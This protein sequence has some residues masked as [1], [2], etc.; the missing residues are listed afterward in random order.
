MSNEKLISETATHDWEIQKIRELQSAIDNYQSLFQS[1]NEGFAFHEVIY[2][3]QGEPVD[4]IFR[5][6]NPKFEEFTGLAKSDILDKRV[7]ECIP[8]IEKAKPNLIE[9]YGLIA[10]D[11]G[12]TS[13]D[14]YFQPFDKW[15]KVSVYRPKQ[16]FFCTLFEDI[17]SRKKAE[18]KLQESLKELKLS[19]EEL[20]QFAYVASHDL[21][22]PLRMV[23][24]YT[25]LLAKRFEGQL[26]EKGDMYI[27]FAMD[28]ARRMQILIDNL[29]E[30]S[31]VSSQ[32]QAF[33]EVDGNQLFQRA[34][35]NIE[36]KIANRNAVVTS[37]Q[38]PKIKA[39][40]QQIIRLF[41]N[42]IC[43]GVKF[44]S[45]QT[46]KVH[47]GYERI[48]NEHVF[49]IE[50]N[51]IGIESRHKKK[52][53]TI[54]QRLHARDEYEGTGIGLSICKRI[55]DRHHGKIWFESIPGEGTTF[56]FAIPV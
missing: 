42:L 44:N 39:D 51:G 32:G 6:I 26:G 3:T 20:E 50:D 29:L 34:I 30:F 5:E 41:Q 31:R 46:P 35:N 49:S 23:Y 45:S 19:N 4:Y 56:F 11:G 28:G 38:L 12:A 52:V 48:K 18:L 25:E 13:F 27:G 14:L 53:F 8:G 2:N 40:G 9:K 47:F 54:F 43:N 24:S 1:M 55:A 7:T 15:Y 16:D 17:S 36:Q 21:Q 10:R 37:E 33:E 22:E